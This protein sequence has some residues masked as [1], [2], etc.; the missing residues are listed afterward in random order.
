MC[1]DEKKKPAPPVKRPIPRREDYDRVNADDDAIP[2]YE[3]TYRD[4]S[5]KN[6][7]WRSE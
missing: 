1:P 3:S 2:E 4:D 5:M 6:E 7:C